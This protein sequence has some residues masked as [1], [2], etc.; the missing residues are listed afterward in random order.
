MELATYLSP[1]MKEKFKTFHTIASKCHKIMVK[2]LVRVVKT[3]FLIH[4]DRML[5]IYRMFPDKNENLL[6]FICKFDLKYCFS[7]IQELAYTVFS[8]ATNSSR[9]AK[10]GKKNF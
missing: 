6:E 7:T 9:Q 5:D 8:E 1:K 2:Y 10:T 3:R 4:A